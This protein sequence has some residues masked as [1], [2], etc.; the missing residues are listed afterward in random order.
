LLLAVL[1]GFCHKGTRTQSLVF[2]FL[3]GFTCFSRRH[4]AEFALFALGSH[5]DA[6]A[7]SPLFFWKMIIFF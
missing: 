4:K 5:K 2:P 1:G 7:Q 3:M 6:K